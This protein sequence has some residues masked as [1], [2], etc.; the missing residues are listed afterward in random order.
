MIKR[1]KL[2]LSI[3]ETILKKY[4]DYS[5]KEGINISRRVEK[6]MRKELGKK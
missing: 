4:K 3:D 5:K 1:K 2:T 6:Y